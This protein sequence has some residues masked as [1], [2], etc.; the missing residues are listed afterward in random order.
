[1]FRRLFHCYLPFYGTYLP[2][3]SHTPPS[4]NNRYISWRLHFWCTISATVLQLAHAICT[5]IKLFC[6]S[7]F[8]PDVYTC[9]EH[10]LKKYS[11]F[12]SKL[13]QILK[14]FNIIHSSQA[15]ELFYYDIKTY[16][17]IRCY[18]DSFS[19]SIIFSHLLHFYLDP[20]FI[21]YVR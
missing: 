21:C 6:V 1:M 12:N 5:V 9:N 17:T 8:F 4:V 18:V 16:I 2:F 15:S 3:S 7:S 14:I 20:S 13:L 11:R 10:L 19:L